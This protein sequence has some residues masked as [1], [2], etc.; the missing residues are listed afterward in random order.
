MGHGKRR[1]KPSFPE[2]S[3]AS[4][5]LEPVGRNTAACAAVAAS[6]VAARADPTSLVLLAPAD[7]LVSSA[8]AFAEA[9]RRGAT[10]ARDGWLVSLGVRPTH[11]ETG[12]GYIRL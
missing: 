4:L 1:C 12:Y 2:G 9:V 7:H 8:E 11:P 3:T 10:A 6:F 5:I